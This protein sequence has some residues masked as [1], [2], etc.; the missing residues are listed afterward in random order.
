[1]ASRIIGRTACPECGFAAAHVKESE[2]CTFRYCPECAAQYHARTSRQIVDL[3]A[4]TRLVD[5]EAAPAATAA[6][7]AAPAAPTEVPPAAAPA[8]APKKRIGLFA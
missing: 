5:V 6:P 7:A 2:K 4:K 1:M 8:P 3:R